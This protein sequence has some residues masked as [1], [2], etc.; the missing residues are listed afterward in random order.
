MFL[1]LFII[2]NIASVPVE[3][4]HMLIEK[5]RKLKRKC[6]YQIN[7]VIWAIHIMEETD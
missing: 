2:T 4:C 5:E 1:K 7:F 3:V 6:P